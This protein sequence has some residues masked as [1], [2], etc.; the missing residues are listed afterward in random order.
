MVMPIYEYRCKK[1]GTTFTQDMSVSNHDKLAS[2]LAHPSMLTVSEHEADVLRC[3]R[4]RELQVEQQ[5][6]SFY[7]KTKKKS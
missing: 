7:A 2:F 5:L 3:P 4:C 1:C 6:S